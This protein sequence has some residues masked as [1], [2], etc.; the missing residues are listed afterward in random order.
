[1]SKRVTL[2]INRTR[3]DI[4]LEDGFATFLSARLKQDFNLEG[5]NDIKVLLQAYV[6]RNY[7]LFEQEKK[8]SDMIK[9]TEGLK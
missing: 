6:Q 5:N 2:T 8:I 3:Y 4:D 1:M 9:K 7:E